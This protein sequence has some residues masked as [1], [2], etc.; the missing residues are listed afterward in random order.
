MLMWKY[1]RQKFLDQFHA[2]KLTQFC[3]VVLLLFSPIGL[4]SRHQLTP[5][6]PRQRT[7]GSVCTSR[8][9]NAGEY[10]LSAIALLIEISRWETHRM[11]V[12]SLWK[13]VCVAA[14]DSGTHIT[15]MK[16][17]SVLL[18]VL[19]SFRRWNWHAILLHLQCYFM[20]CQS[21]F[22]EISTPFFF[23]SLSLFGFN[24]VTCCT[25]KLLT[26]K[27]AGCFSST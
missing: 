22:D 25:V 12:R 18:T 17:Q 2:N 13:T 3:R 23:L 21:F 26:K 7:H 27:L 14:T 8:K 9:C 4:T 20:Y 10:C 5:Q 24:A 6:S 19:S 15:S 1:N 16:R 11:T